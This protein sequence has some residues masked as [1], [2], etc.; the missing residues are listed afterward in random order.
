MAITYGTGSQLLEVG[1]VAWELP[2]HATLEA[3]AQILGCSHYHLKHLLIGPTHAGNLDLVMTGLAEAQIKGQTAVIALHLAG[4]TETLTLLVPQHGGLPLHQSSRQPRQG[5][6]LVAG[7]IVSP[8]RPGSIHS[9]EVG[10]RQV[11]M[12][13][14][15]GVSM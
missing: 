12:L 10:E 3:N 15:C 2:G 9:A 1:H 14:V 4:L 7:P 13:L 6:E 11:S 5:S 8:P